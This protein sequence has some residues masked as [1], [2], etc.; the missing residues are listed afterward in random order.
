MK[1]IPF[2]LFNFLVTLLVFFYFLFWEF[3]IIYLFKLR[4][5][6]PFASLAWEEQ[7]MFL[8]WLLDAV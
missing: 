8:R 3:F 6:S 7:M 2:V 4:L 1:F 5:M